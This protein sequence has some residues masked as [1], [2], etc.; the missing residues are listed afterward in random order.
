MSK[1]DLDPATISNYLYSVPFLYEAN[2][3][4]EPFFPPDSGIW[5]LQKMLNLTILQD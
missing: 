2:T 5:V 4:F 1:L 3:C